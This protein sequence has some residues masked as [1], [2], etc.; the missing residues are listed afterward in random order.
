VLA[1]LGLGLLL[2]TGYRS[3]AAGKRPRPALGT[4]RALLVLLALGPVAVIVLYSSRPHA[5]FLLSR[6]L[7]VAVPYALLLFGALLTSVRPRWAAAALSVAA[8]AAVAVG[9]VKMLTP[10]YRRPDS[11]AAAR[12][13]DAKAPPEAVLAD[14]GGPQSV[15][16]YLAGR[17]PITMFPAVPPSAWARAARAGSP[18]FISSMQTPVLLFV[19]PARYAPNY[20]LV[21]S[22]SWP[23]APYPITVREFAPR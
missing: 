12:Y 17:R 10:D 6:N 19:P 11:R 9:T 13:I 4:R 1:V 15:R 2:A 3:H 22:R 21:A 18:V 7:S 5:S 16:L 14:V 8:L 23:G 20:R